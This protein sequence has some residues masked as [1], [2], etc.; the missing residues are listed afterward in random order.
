[1][2]DAILALKWVQENIPFFG[3][4]PNSVTVQGHSAGAGL[5]HLLSL[6]NKTEGL[7]HKIIVQSG[8]GFASWS[9]HPRA[10][11][12]NTSIEF[13]NR[14]GCEGADPP[15]VVMNG[16]ENLQLATEQA[17]IDMKVVDCLR[18]K[19]LETLF[20]ASNFFVS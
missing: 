18:G 19:D 13:A 9:F 12:R 14:A 4:D 17:K 2:K 3:G 5:T 1:M 16:E 20:D 6:T 10:N 7:F 11:I 15:L 8:T